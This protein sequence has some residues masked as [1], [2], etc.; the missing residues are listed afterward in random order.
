MASEQPGLSELEALPLYRVARVPIY[1]TRLRSRL[2]LLALVAIDIVFIVAHLVATL[3]EVRV[4]A[5]DGVPANLDIGLVANLPWAWSLLKLV[6]G[7]ALAALMVTAHPVDRRPGL[8]W[9]SAAVVLAALTLA[10]VAQL[11]VLWA[12]GVAPLIFGIE[13]PQLYGLLGRLL[14]LELIV[15]AGIVVSARR[16][17]GAIG[18]FVLAGLL[19]VV[20]E[21]PIPASIIEA[22]DDAFAADTLATAWRG[23]I[24]SFG[25]SFLL[26]AIAFAMRDCQAVSVRYVY[27]G[28]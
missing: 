16:S 17:L 2:F 15:L 22:I 19:F 3:P 27:R 10:E 12:A 25:I 6:V 11:H 28:G 5:P 4:V 1:V 23:G 14:P 13:A 18:A 7:A 26:A 9:R 8:F 20:S 21:S 24:D